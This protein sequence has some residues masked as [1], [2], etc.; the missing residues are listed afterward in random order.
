MEERALTQKENRDDKDTP[1]HSQMVMFLIGGAGDKRSYM[2]SGPNNNIISIY[3]HLNNKYQSHIKSGRLS[4][5]HLGY[6][7]VFGE[8]R[9]WNVLNV[10]RMYYKID[11]EIFLKTNSVMII[12]HSLGDWNGAHFAEN[13]KTWKRIQKSKKL[14]KASPNGY[15]VK[16]LIT[17][18][19]A[20]EG[21]TV[22]TF[23]EIYFK[24][25]KLTIKNWINLKYDQAGYSFPDFVADLGGQWNI[26]AGP[27]IN[28][29]VSIDHALTSSAMKVKLKSI[30][31][32][33][34][35]ELHSEIDKFVSAS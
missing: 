16:M 12:G 32:S 25:A 35:D 17:L 3:D 15:D 20:G 19:P 28:E 11:S 24:P 30:Q 21:L 9:I 33:A 14:H 5:E 10:Q 1:I 31:R 18:D 23:S 27:R 4:L 26:T 13:L 6:Y 29:V 22:G 8:D 2:G 7:D 34:F